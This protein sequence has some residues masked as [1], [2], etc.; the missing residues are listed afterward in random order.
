M[1]LEKEDKD[2]VEQWTKD[3]KHLPEFMRDFHAQK[4]IFKVMHLLYEDG[5]KDKPR[6]EMPNWRDGMCY[7]IDWF[8]WYMAQRGYTLQKNRTKIKFK[9]FEDRATLQKQ[10][11]MIWEVEA[12]IKHNHYSFSIGD[13][14]E[15]YKKYQNCDYISHTFKKTIENFPQYFD[16]RKKS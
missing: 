7:V 2:I 4:D 11:E 6:E 12:F 5:N 16:V 3:E 13:V 15:E 14:M 9:E 1:P 8:L 10:F